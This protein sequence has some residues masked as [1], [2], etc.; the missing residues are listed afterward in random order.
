VNNK[1]KKQK[2]LSRRNMVALA[3]RA[4]FAPGRGA[5]THGDMKKE[6]SRKACRNRVYHP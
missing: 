3:M 1:K 4:R 5:G 2:Q 6:A